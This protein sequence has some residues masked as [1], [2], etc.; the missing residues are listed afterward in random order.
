MMS[1]KKTHRSAGFTIIELT[2]ATLVFSVILVVIVSAVLSFTK[3]YYRGVTVSATQN[4]TRSIVDSV[5]QSIQ[6]SSPLLIKYNLLPVAGGINYFCAGGYSYVY[7]PGQQY[8]PS[9]A[10][11]VNAVGMYSYPITS[12]GCPPPALGVFPAGYKQLLSKGMRVTYFSIVQSGITW[13]I[14]IRI[15]DGDF[16]LLTGVTGKDVRCKS[17]TGSQFCAVSGIQTAVQGRVQ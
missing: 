11:A 12:G 3:S 7:I 9:I 14:N 2:I 15:A 13:T 6:F 16:D 4:A 8:D 1:V 10:G 17:L 5:N